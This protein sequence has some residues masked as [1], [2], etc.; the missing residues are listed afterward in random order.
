MTPEQWLEC[1][2]PCADCPKIS[3]RTAK[4]ECQHLWRHL[5]EREL[6]QSGDGTV[7]FATPERAAFLGASVSKQEI[8]GRRPSVQ[9]TTVEPTTKH[10]FLKALIREN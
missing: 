9:I 1:K 8:E 10:N 2:V 3:K 6:E 5:V 4:E 7:P